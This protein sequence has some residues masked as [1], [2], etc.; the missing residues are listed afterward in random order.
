[1]NLTFNSTT[2]VAAKKLNRKFIG[3]EKFEKEFNIAEKRIKES[4]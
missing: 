4:K 3:I 2:G 1:M